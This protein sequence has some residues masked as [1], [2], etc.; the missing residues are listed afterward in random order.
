M[1]GLRSRTV[2]WLLALAT[3]SLPSFAAADGLARIH[4]GA[5]SS[6]SARSPEGV[7]SSVPASRTREDAADCDLWGQSCTSSRAGAHATRASVQRRRPAGRGLLPAAADSAGR[8]LDATQQALD[9]I[10]DPLL[11]STAEAV[12][13]AAGTALGVGLYAPLKLVEHVLGEP[14]RR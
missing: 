11:A 7:P 9:P 3:A 2:I 5:R 12:G 6:A 8:S 4:A 13:T 14:G 1:F 10:V